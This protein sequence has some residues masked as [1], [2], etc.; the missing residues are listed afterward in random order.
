MEDQ[1]NGR[2]H[3]V[4]SLDIPHALVHFAVHKEDVFEGLPVAGEDIVNTEEACFRECSV[5]IAVDP[6]YDL[7]VRKPFFPLTSATR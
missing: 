1:I 5:Q 2:D 6:P 3:L 4:H 7:L